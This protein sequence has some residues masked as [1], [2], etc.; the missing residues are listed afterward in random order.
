MAAKAIEK[1]L[2]DCVLVDDF[3]VELDISSNTYKVELDF[4]DFRDSRD[5]SEMLKLKNKIRSVV[6]RSYKIEITF[7]I[8][9]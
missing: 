8:T 4:A 1:V 3:E 7:L 5:A 6:N 9:T 2:N